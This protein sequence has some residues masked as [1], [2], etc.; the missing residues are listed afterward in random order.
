[1]FPTAAAEGATQARPRALAPDVTAAASGQGG[2]KVK[3]KRGRVLAFTAGGAVLAAA[4]VVAVLTFS[5]GSGQPG[6]PVADA[7]ATQAG[8]ADNALGEVAPGTPTITAKRIGTT[9]KVEFSWTY[10]NPQGG[11]SFELDQTIADKQ[12][13]TTKH[14]ITVTVPP[15]QAVCYAVRVYRNG[16]QSEQSSPTCSSQ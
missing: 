14:E 5:Q 12:T 4:A 2:A 10:A 7:P 1:V 3:G 11:D 15:G 6:T 16:Q 8:G 9:D 13:E